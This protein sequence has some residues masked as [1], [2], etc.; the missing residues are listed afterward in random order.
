V[1]VVWRNAIQGEVRCAAD[2]LPLSSG[3]VMRE[4]GNQD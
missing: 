3:M 4:Y 2:E 1:N